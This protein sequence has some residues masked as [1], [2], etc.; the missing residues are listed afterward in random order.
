MVTIK[1]MSLAAPPRAPALGE[2]AHGYLFSIVV[3]K[4]CDRMLQHPAEHRRT[5]TR[6]YMLHAAERVQRLKGT[7]RL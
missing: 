7:Q 2:G 1:T 4:P 3:Q 6:L 5:H